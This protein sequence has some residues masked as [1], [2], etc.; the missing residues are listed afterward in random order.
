MF[1][2][3]IIPCMWLL[4][5]FG[6]QLTVWAVSMQVWEIGSQLT[7]Q[8]VKFTVTPITVINDQHREGARIRA[9]ID[10][11]DKSKGYG[12]GVKYKSVILQKYSTISHH[13]EYN[14]SIL[15]KCVG[16]I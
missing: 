9:K 12:S 16:N 5:R 8:L 4:E 1:I 2:V 11:V 10:M 14:R 15:T 3:L 13:K 6:L 7:V